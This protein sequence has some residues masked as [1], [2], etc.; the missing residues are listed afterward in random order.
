[1]DGKN[2]LAFDLL[3]MF[4]TIVNACIWANYFKRPYL[5]LSFKAQLV[6][7][8]VQYSV[9]ASAIASLNVFSIWLPRANC[10]R[11]ANKAYFFTL[12]LVLPDPAPFPCIRRVWT[13]T[14]LNPES[15][16]CKACFCSSGDGLRGVGKAL[17]SSGPNNKGKDKLITLL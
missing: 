1:M 13:L 10:Q 3:H 12:L 15:E 7:F 11:R 8:L 2:C 14:L 5:R 6:L 4:C 16:I 9:V 17:S